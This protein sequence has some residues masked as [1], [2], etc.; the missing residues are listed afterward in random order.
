MIGFVI[1]AIL[2]IGRYGWR[3]YWHSGWNRFDLLVV[4]LGSGVIR[5]APGEVAL[6]RRMGKLHGSATGTVVNLPASG[7][8][9]FGTV[10]KDNDYLSEIVYTDVSLT[11]SGP[12]DVTAPVIGDVQIETSGIG[13]TISWLAQIRQLA[14]ELL[15][16][17]VSHSRWSGP[18]DHGG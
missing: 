13:A 7:Y 2:K 14:V 10:S 16:P 5:V 4:V 12:A 11:T 3:T 6:V 8:V 9:G 1:E 15:R 18:S 17:V